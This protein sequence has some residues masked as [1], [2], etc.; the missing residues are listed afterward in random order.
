M[1]TCAL[2]TTSSLKQ[3]VVLAAVLGVAFA[4]AA[5]ATPSHQPCVQTCS[6]E[7]HAVSLSSDSTWCEVPQLEPSRGSSGHQM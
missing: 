6:I 4:A 3:V 1:T 5:A 7:L 2:C